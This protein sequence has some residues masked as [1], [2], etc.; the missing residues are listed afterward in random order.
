MTMADRQWTEA[1]N[2]LPTG[3]VW[4][5]LGDVCSD[6]QYG[7]TTSASSEGSIQFLRTTDITSGVI[8]WGSV[9]FCL[10]A[11]PDIDKYLLSDGD[12]VISRAG[13]VGYSILIKSPKQAVFASYLIRF[14]P[15]I[16]EHYVAYF[17][18]SPSYWQAISE[19]RLGIAIPNVNA[20]K[21]RQIEF[22]L[23]PL[24]EQ[25]RIVAKIEELFTDLDAG[26]AALKRVQAALKRYKASVLKA[27]CEGR[28]VPQDASDEPADILLA[29]ILAERRAKW[30]ADQRVKGK[31]PK[32]AKYE[33]PQPPDT[34]GL[35]ALPEGW[36]W[37]TF[38]MVGEVQGGIQKQPKRTPKKNAYPYLRVANVMRGF[39]DLSE[40]YEIELFGD[41]LEKLRLQAGDLLIVEGNGSQNEIGRSA[42][43]KGEIVNCVHQNHIIRVRFSEIQS[44]Y[45]SHYLNSPS[46]ISYMMS[47]A[48]ST[49]GLYTLSTSKVKAIA[50]PL[51][52]IAEQNR[53]V[54]E[55][56]RRLSVVAEMEKTVKD[57][58]A[59]AGRL[60][61]AILHRAFSGRLVPQDPN[62]EPAEKLLERIRAGK[63][64]GKTA[65]VQGELFETPSNGRKPAKSR[66]RRGKASSPK[67]PGRRKGKGTT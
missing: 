14:R 52:P 26:V 65:P 47:V 37:A 38:D 54:A 16:D 32:K 64:S 46:G 39:L 24:S 48:A 36:V 23:A 35:L 15:K 9:P 27:A 51:P 53:I 25:H 61:Q 45:A 49:S 19:Q 7:W 63:E 17:L 62:D 43:W 20:S 5:T 58:L 22:P 4:T 57:N 56:E 60:R 29:R 50:I 3:W 28:L 34:N 11:P 1:E 30:E 67:A 10:E 31:D 41:E 18:Q 6:S 55:V 33:E 21:L 59:R 2:Q 13:S 40:V 8:D 42:L 66:A 44:A 12:I